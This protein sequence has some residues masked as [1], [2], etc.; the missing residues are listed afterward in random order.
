VM[1]AWGKGHGVG[2]PVAGLRVWA[3]LLGVLAPWGCDC[4]CRPRA[5]WAPNLHLQRGC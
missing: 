2:G 1:G 5:P 4:D 3:G